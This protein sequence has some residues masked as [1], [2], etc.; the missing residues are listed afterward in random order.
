MKYTYNESACKAEWQK[1]ESKIKTNNIVCAIF[2]SLA[3]IAFIA[4]IPI[5]QCFPDNYF[6]PV[7][8]AFIICGIACAV[9]SKCAPR[10]TLATYVYELAKDGNIK[11]FEYELDGNLW[12][13]VWIEN[14]KSGN[15][16]RYHLPC[17]K[18]TYN[19]R[20]TEPVLD[21]SQGEAQFPY[22]PTKK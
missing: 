14:P 1:H 20:V 4:L 6:Y 13:W 19:T 3:I 8:W 11:D 16:T 21:I 12:L 22:P 18:Y 15:V 7:L 17:P 9:V 2:A 10:A 5:S